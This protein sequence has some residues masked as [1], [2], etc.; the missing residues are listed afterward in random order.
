MSPE[1]FTDKCVWEGGI[2]EVFSYGFRVKDLDDSDPKFKEILREF[3]V[4]WL[5]ADETE[6]ELIK[7]RYNK[8]ME[9]RNER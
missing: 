6:T 9:K 7:Y 4:Y 8:E 1:E 5:K 3:E 2:Y